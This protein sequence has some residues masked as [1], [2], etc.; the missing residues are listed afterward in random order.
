MARPLERPKSE[1]VLEQ[2][3]QVV[4]PEDTQQDHVCGTK[5]AEERVGPV[6]T[7]PH[8]G[9]TRGDVPKIE[10]LRVLLESFRKST[11]SAARH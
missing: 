9:M 7:L 1:L 10:T 8:S 6:G 3:T 2:L 5:V 4:C 11:S